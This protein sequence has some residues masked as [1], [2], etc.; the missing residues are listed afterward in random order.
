MN[1]A[2]KL[3]FLSEKGTMEKTAYLQIALGLEIKRMTGFILGQLPRALGWKIQRLF[4]Y[5]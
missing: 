2:K 5:F 1:A 4:W 3:S